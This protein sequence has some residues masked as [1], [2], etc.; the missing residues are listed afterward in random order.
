LEIKI[1]YTEEAERWLKD[2]FDYYVKVGGLSVAQKVIFLILEE[3][4]NLIYNS[5]LGQKEQLLGKRKFDY[6]SIF[7]KDYKV[8]YRMEKNYIIISTIFDTRKKLQ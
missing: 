2:I 5:H 4:E 7:I 6:Y 3:T 8:I 1:Y